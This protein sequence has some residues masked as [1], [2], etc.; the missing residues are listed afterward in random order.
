M[1]EDTFSIPATIGVADDEFGAALGHMV[2]K[3][4]ELQR[5]EDVLIFFREN[6]DPHAL[7]AGFC[8]GVYIERQ[9]ELEREEI[10]TNSV[11]WSKRLNRILSDLG[12]AEWSR[13]ES[14]ALMNMVYLHSQGRRYD[15]VPNQ[16]TKVKAGFRRIFGEEA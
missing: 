13:H 4:G 10:A 9:D 8:M 11:D 6:H 3:A 15:N 16:T 12:F 2:K 14:D 1:N 7:L 5:R